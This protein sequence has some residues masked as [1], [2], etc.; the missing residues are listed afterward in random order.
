[1][2]ASTEHHLKGIAHLLVQENLLGKEKVSF[3][4]KM[5]AKSG[6]SLLSY[7]VINHIICPTLIATSIAEH[8][9]MPLIDLDCVD[10]T[11]IPTKLISDKLIRCHRMVPIFHEGAQVSVATDDPSQ[12]EALQELQFHTG[13]RVSAVLVESHKLTKLI[14]QLLHENENQILV[15]LVDTSMHHSNTADSSSDDEP[16]VKFVKRIILDAI[17][18]GASDIHFEPY[19]QAYRI[20]YRQDGLLIVVATPPYSLSSRL[21]ARLKVMASLDISEKRIPQDGRFRMPYA[22]MQAIDFRVSTCPTV[23]GEK[24]VLRILD[25]KATQPNLQTLGFLPEQKT[26]FSNAIARSQGMILV[27]GPTG[28]GKT[29]TLYCALNILNTGERNILS[30]EDPVEI[31]VHGINQVNIY[32]KA[33]LTF[34]SALRAFLR[35]D[36]DVIM[37]GEIRDI[38][39]AEIAIKAAH[40]GHLVLSTLHTNSAAETLTRLVNMGVPAFNVAS[41]ISLIIAQRLVRRLCN[42]CK[43]ANNE[44]LLVAGYKAQGCNQCTDGYRGRIALFEVLPISKNITQMIMS[45]KNSHDLLKQAQIEGMLTLAEAGLEQVR[46]GH[47]SIEEINRVIVD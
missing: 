9:G 27:T 28:C 21:A 12:H 13:L 15:N 8:F 35:Q 4:Q 34:A 20:R 30:V 38:E 45:G 43:I 10:I 22:P 6:A 31:N 14:N 3:Y 24:I 44:E 46:R 29:M 41:S 7:L 16:V 32:P 42:A 39:T 47:T 1:M 37:I 40:T 36:P 23:S 19:E 2:D 26:H 33:G 11:S 25:T 17:E 5:A 18:Q